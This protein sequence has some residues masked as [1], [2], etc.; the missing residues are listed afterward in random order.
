[1]TDINNDV[2]RLDGIVCR[3]VLYFVCLNLTLFMIITMAGCNTISG[4]GQD[5][6]AVA[7]G[8]QDWMADEPS[9]NKER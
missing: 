9:V 4:I 6:Q 2:K 8:T 7:Q 5:L 3:V 1:M